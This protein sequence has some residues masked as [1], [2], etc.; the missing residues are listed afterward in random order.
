MKPSLGLT[1]FA[2]LAIAACTTGGVNTVTSR[3]LDY[4]P[5]VDMK[6]VDAIRYQADLKECKEYAAQIDVGGSALA[7]ALVGAAAGAA[8]GAATGAAVGRA[9][10]GAAIGSAAGGTGGLGGGV[11][12]ATRAQEQM[13]HR[14]LI[15][16]GYNI[17]Y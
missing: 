12:S 7:G 15:G 14:C 13:I 9:G 8:V 4:R 10:T 17:L 1:N 2:S 6:G 3:G 11:V 5:I 16:R